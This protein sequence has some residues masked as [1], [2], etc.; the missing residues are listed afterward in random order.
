MYHQGFSPQKKQEKFLV[1]ETQHLDC[2]QS[3]EKSSMLET[4][5]K[6]VIITTMSK[7]ILK[8]KE[9]HQLK[10]KSKHQKEKNSVTVESLPK[11]KKTI[12]KDRS[13]TSK[14]NTPIT[15]LSKILEA[16]LTSREKVLK[17][18][19]NQQSKEKSKEWWLPTKTDCVVS[20]LTLLN[21][22]LRSF[23]KE[24]S[25]FSTILTVPQNKKW[26]PMFYLSSLSSQ[27]ESMDS[28]NTNIKSR[29]NLP[30][31]KSF[32]KNRKIRI[33]P[34]KKQ[35]HLLEEWFG[36]FRWFYNRAIDYCEEH[37]EYD[38]RKVRNN[39]RENT[40]FVFPDWCQNTPSK[41][42][43]GA[44][45]DC[46]KAYK[47]CFSQKKSGIVTSFKV[48]YKTK[49]DKGSH[50]LYLEKGCFSSAK[51][52]VLFPRTFG[53]LKGVYNKKQKLNNI[54]IDHD[55]RIVKKEDK[56]YLF[57]P[58]DYKVLDHI[59]MGTIALDS[60]IRTFQTGYS[61]DDLAVEIGKDCSLTLN[62]LLKKTDTLRSVASESNKRKN[63]KL[64][65]R[66]KRINLKIKNKVDDLHWKTIKFLTSNY[67]TIL[68]SD[69][70]SG[71]LLKN[72]KLGKKSKRILC[73]LEHFSFKNRLIYKC[74]QNGNKV[75]FVDESYTSKTCCN[76]GELNYNLG[77]KKI[78]ECENCK[79]V[80]DRDINAAKN[81]L[82][83]NWNICSSA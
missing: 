25:W 1:L 78:F 19:W 79:V 12:S 9:I 44:I 32:L 77:A 63:R 26:S 57:L 5:K 70:K 61:P 17:P 34:N 50:C 74:E 28:E 52:G 68:V 81:I 23:P 22:S 45:S 49:K 14:K 71:N 80:I 42:V 65:S 31:Q 20:D 3:P 30:N 48:S 82:L 76:C 59:P 54:K 29:K 6:E 46:C 33:Y 58:T 75:F 69:F 56:Y 35:I 11:D 37:K 18:F 83:K 38:F 62:P 67:D 24:K 16:D 72:K 21:G 47:T 40:K 36:A 2:G 55:C 4:E 27:Q 60:G 13:L 51:N 41:I 15:R 53:N 39:M 73:L 10:R 64:F 66:I 43:S 8:Q 7:N